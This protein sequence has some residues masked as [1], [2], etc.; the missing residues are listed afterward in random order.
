METV[1]HSLPG[2][3]PLNNFTVALL[4]R[5]WLSKKAFEIELSRPSGFTFQ[6]GQRIRFVH[7][8]YERDYSI[9]STPKDQTLSICVRKV[10]GGRF[11]PQLAS[12]GIGARF[13]ITGPLGYFTF[14]KS[15][16][17]T[18]FVGTGTGIAPFVSMARSGAKAFT[19]LHG[20]SL[21]EDLYYESELRSATKH[22]IPCLSE[23][24]SGISPP[25]NSF[26]GRVTG[27]LETHLPHK[28]YDFY[29]CGGSEMIRDVTLLVDD[30]FTGSYIYTEIF[31]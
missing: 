22:Y 16:R 13:E 14:R 28:A 8:A 2:D 30:R 4:K 1:D 10:K 19:L 25:K 26:L 20:V 11:S 12:D 6:P 31:Y 9:V 23:T 5:T 3:A 15:S 7:N 27:Y 21:P 29:L 24:P 17:Q 18:I